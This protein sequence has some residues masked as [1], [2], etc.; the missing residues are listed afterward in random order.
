[1]QAEESF[2][3][4]T[5]D[6]IIEL[7]R[8]RRNELITK[9]LDAAELNLFLKESFGITEVSLIKQEFI[10]RALKELELSPINLPHYGQIILEI[11]KTGSLTISSDNEKRF[12]L[13]IR[14]SIKNYLL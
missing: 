8:E 9:L 6:N 10:K 14:N 1:M 12:Y 2:I 3:R 7:V 13:D 4:L 11:R 5:N